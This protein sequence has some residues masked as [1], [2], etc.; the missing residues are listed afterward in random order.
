MPWAAALAVS[1]G[2]PLSHGGKAPVA[3]RPRA[4]LRPLSA[5][6]FLFSPEQ[7]NLF[8]NR[9]Q[10][11]RVPLLSSGRPPGSRPARRAGHARPACFSGACLA[12]RL[13]AGPFFSFLLLASL[14]VNVYILSTFLFFLL[15]FSLNSISSTAAPGK[16]GT[17]CKEMPIS[18]YIYC[19][20]PD[21][22]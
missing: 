9:L 11:R 2:P 14:F 13:P 1:R 8:R 21:V 5:S 22:S 12:S 3:T 17:F 15:V 19:I 16:T 6:S 18:G 10:K 4:A 7:I 20:F